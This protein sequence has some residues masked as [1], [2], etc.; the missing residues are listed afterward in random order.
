[1]LKEMP[2][3]D[4]AI[5]P[6]E[7]ERFDTDGLAER[8]GFRRDT[9]LVYLYRRSFHRIPK[10]NRADREEAMEGIRVEHWAPAPPRHVGSTP[11]PRSASEPVADTVA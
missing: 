2:D 9:V 3:I 7:Y 1:M 11:K 4:Y 10:P 6:A 8:L 5:V